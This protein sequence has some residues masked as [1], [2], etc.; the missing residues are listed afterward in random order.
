MSLA[1]TPSLSLVPDVRI[2]YGSIGDEIENAIRPS[3]RVRWSF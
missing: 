2:D 1:L 3:I